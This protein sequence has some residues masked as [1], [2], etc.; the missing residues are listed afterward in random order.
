MGVIVVATGNVAKF[1]EIKEILTRHGIIAR[2]PDIKIDVREGVVSYEENA[3]IKASYLTSRLGADAL[4]EDSGIEVPALGGFPVVISARF[5]EGSD[6]DRN[7]ALLEKMK[8]IKS[9]DRKAV[10]KAYVVITL[11]DGGYLTGYGELGG[12]IT[13]KPEGN[14]GF[15]YDP[16]F[17]PDGY[18]RSLA[19]LSGDEKNTISHRRKAIEAVLGQYVKYRV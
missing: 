7:A 2:M 18:D 9:E 5:I 6:R 13:M 16:I 11:K 10:F 15:G 8:H 4:G 3:K 19:I 1:K 14:N 17:I 12:R